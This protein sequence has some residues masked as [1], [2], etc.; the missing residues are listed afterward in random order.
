VGD[1]AQITTTPPPQG[2]DEEVLDLASQLLSW[3]N[4]Y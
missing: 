4:N 1:A 3:R 2:L